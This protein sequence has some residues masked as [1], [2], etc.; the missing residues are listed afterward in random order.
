MDKRIN[1]KVSQHILDFKK[2]LVENVPTSISEKDKLTFLNFIYNFPIITIDKTD[3]QKRKR[4]K[5]HVP[6]CDKC[7]ALRANGEQCSRRKKNNDKFCGTHIKGIPH[8]EISNKPPEKTHKSV[9]VWI[10]EIH[11]ISYYIDS[12]NNVY[13]HNDIIHNKIN[14]SIIA[15]YEIGHDKHYSIPSLNH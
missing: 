14:P 2:K 1:R 12:D 6:L 13:N 15:K 8:G 9:S 5:N 4:V 11:G 10:Q 3:L 7:R